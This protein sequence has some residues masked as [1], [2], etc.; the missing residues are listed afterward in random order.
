MT[1]I[2][3]LST[4]ND[5]IA[6]LEKLNTEKLF[7]EKQLVEYK[8]KYAQTAAKLDELEGEFHKLLNKCDVR[9]KI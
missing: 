1:S 3:S 7:I 5:E 2:S 9:L 6:N 8:L 4:S